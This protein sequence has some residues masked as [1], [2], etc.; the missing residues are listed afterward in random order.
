MSE[1]FVLYMFGLSKIFLFFF[2]FLCFDHDFSID[3]RIYWQHWIT[4]HPSWSS[5]VEHS[6]SIWKICI[7]EPNASL[8]IVHQWL[9]LSLHFSSF[10]SFNWNSILVIKWRRQRQIWNMMSMNGV[11]AQW[12][13]YKTEKLSFTITTGTTEYQTY[14]QCETWQTSHEF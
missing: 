12:M 8:F 5:I 2:L 10:S 3:K 9:I 4:W 7:V 13:R 6:L 1:W 14:K 11:R